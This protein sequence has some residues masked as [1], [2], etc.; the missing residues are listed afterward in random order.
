MIN[1]ECVPLIQ[2]AYF[3][4]RLIFNHK[5]SILVEFAAPQK[6]GLQIWVNKFKRLLNISPDSKLESSLMLKTGK[7]SVG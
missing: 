1:D 6:I 2:R 7:K 3:D 5:E 4:K